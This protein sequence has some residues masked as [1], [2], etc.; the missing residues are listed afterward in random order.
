M[1]R[2]LGRIKVKRCKFLAASRFLNEF[3]F[4]YFIF[5]I[6]L[7]FAK[8]HVPGGAVLKVENL[9]I[10]YP[11]KEC[12]IYYIYFLNAIAEDRCFEIIEEPKA[13]IFLYLACAP[14]AMKTY[15]FL[16]HRNFSHKELHEFF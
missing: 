5:N 11:S 6:F 7:F 9:L 2:E 12:E 4:I 3:L 16:L 1:E 10:I 8:N 14:D 15:G 13:A